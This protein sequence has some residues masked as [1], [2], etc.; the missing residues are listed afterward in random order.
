MVVRSSPLIALGCWF[1]KELSVLFSK[2][3]KLLLRATIYSSTFYGEQGALFL[4]FPG[5]QRDE[6]S[7]MSHILNLHRQNALLYFPLDEHAEKAAEAL[8]AG[9]LVYLER[10]ES[11][12]LPF[13]CI[14]LAIHCCSGVSAPS[15]LLNIF[16]VAS[17]CRWESTDGRCNFKSTA[18][19]RNLFYFAG[20]RKLED[21]WIQ[22]LKTAHCSSPHNQ[23]GNINFNMSRSRSV[24]HIIGQIAAQFCQTE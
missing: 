14:R 20:K 2:K 12:L 13:C 22:D 21:F 11:L 8:A 19:E 6:I 4:L 10:L 1:K 9:P 16:W 24:L 17:V 15:L 5:N 7:F 18:K 23:L 3:W